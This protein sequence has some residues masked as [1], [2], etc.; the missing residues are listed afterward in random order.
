MKY[1]LM[2]KL[3]AWNI[4]IKNKLEISLPTKYPN[5][6]IKQLK[7]LKIDIYKITYNKDSINLVIN[8]ED[9]ESI[10]KYYHPHI[11]KFIG[12]KGWIN[13][14]K[15]LKRNIILLIFI[16]ICITLYTKIIINI[17]IFTN[18]QYLYKKILNELDKENITK[19]TLIKDSKTIETIKKNILSR[20]K[21]ILEWINIKRVGMTYI[22][23]LEPKIVKEPSN[24]NTYC[25]I[26]STKDAIITKIYSSEGIELKEIND[27]VKKGDILISGDIKKDEETKGTTCATG[28]VW[29]QTWYTINIE[30]PKTYNKKEKSN[31]HKYNI[32][33]KYKNRNK[34]ILKSRFKDYEPTDK[35]IINIFGFEI[36]LRKEEKIVLKKE[37]YTEDE[38][39]I[40]IN[41]LIEEKMKINLG[42]KSKII[43]KKVLKKV[44]KD[45]KIYLEVFIV[46]EEEISKSIDATLIP[47]E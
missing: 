41:N 8:Q 46:A 47:K 16:I 19:Y 28:S 17:E 24:S 2:E 4:S 7:Y 43:D 38:L 3:K 39:N 1:C 12:P 15:Q 40:Q 23:N 37:Q 30:I 34:S 14:I 20:N 21:D 27:S 36:Y 31:K 32:L 25:H 45:S 29:G 22:I 44:D 26:I 6:T 42:D 18:N 35:K 10:K 13:T 33:L 9:Y 5:I 11:I